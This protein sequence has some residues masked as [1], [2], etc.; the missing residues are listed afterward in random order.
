M[1]D[2]ILTQRQ[3]E[4]RGRMKG[5][6]SSAGVNEEESSIR[7][8]DRNIRSGRYEEDKRIRRLDEQLA[9]WKKAEDVRAYALAVEAAVVKAQG[10]GN[11]ASELGKWIAWMRDYASRLDPSSRPDIGRDRNHW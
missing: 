10:A 7:S 9:A 11:E 3:A 4:M 2:T 5:D 6:R 1:A 8:G